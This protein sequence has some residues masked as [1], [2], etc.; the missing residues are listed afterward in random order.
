MDVDLETLPDLLRAQARSDPARPFV[1]F[2]ERALTYGEFDARTDA[3]AGGLA[4]LGVRAG[5]VVSVFLPNCIEFLEAWWAILKAGGVLGPINPA[6][7]A[8]EAGYII[9]HSEAV[10]LVTDARG[11]GV[12]AGEVSGLRSVISIDGG[13]DVR[14]DE[15]AR[16]DT[17]APARTRD[18]L[19]AILY[20]SGTTGRP[21]GAMLTH[22]NELSKRRWGQS[23]CR[24]AR[25]TAS[26]CCCR[27]SM[28]TRRS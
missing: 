21:K 14:L 1:R 6:Y 9:E 7:T 16:G 24:W 28:P 3:L 4:E 19:A 18:D 22:R 15:L 5:D 26:A 10:A 23:C 13:G 17:P 8:S 2:K 27:S 11:A 20:T 25:V 12:V